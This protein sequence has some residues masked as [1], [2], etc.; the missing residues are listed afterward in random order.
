[1]DV[2][3]L[4]QEAK[5]WQ[6]AISSLLGFVAL[7][8][9]ALFNFRLN[10]KR[11]AALRDDEALVVVAALYGEILALRREAVRL[12]QATATEYIG[13]GISGVPREP[14][15]KH[16][17]EGNKLSEPVLFR[18]LAP[19][20]GMLRPNLA[21]AIISFHLNIQ[22]ARQWIPLLRNDSERRFTYSPLH[23]LSPA[24]AAIKDVVPA[25]RDI[26]ATLRLSPHEDEF[27]L[28]RVEGVILTEETSYAATGD[29]N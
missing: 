6:G 1:M 17:M 12:V 28:T 11:D 18:A 4:Y 22:E 7:L 19:K 9:G 10:R 23:I 8:G 15:D 5:S 26:E 13:W 3:I 21:Q 24:M 16:F 2:A 25:L 29:N 14:F 20:I 27:D